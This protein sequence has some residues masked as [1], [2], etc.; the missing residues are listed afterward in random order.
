M[1]SRLINFKVVNYIIYKQCELHILLLN[2]PQ[3]YLKIYILKK[4]NMK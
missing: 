3:R 1:R 4:Y 2:K